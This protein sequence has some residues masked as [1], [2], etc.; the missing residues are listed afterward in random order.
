[1]NNEYK[2]WHICQERAQNYAFENKSIQLNCSHTVAC[3]YLK[4]LKNETHHLNKSLST[5]IEYQ[6]QMLTS[7]EGCLPSKQMLHI[8]CFKGTS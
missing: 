2:Q 3:T 8:L 7:T 5:P 1:M 6:V 4:V